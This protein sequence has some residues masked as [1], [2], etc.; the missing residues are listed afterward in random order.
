[1]NNNI[2]SKIIKSRRLDMNLSQRELAS[3]MK[4]DVKTISEIEKGIRRKPKIATLEKLAEELY[5]EIE[6]LLGYAGYSDEEI[7]G[8]YEDDSIIKQVPFNY[9]LTIVG[10]GLIEIEDIETAQ[11]KAAELIS[12]MLIETIGVSDE[13]DNLL[14]NSQNCF[15][16]IN[17]PKG[18]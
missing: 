17:I 8:Y 5:I 4:C 16:C 9:V 2:L 13:W 18:E 15:V 14:E 7:C 3:R 10:Q 1:M 6:D 12:D 11:N